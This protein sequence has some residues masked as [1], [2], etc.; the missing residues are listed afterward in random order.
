MAGKK[1]KQVNVR[2]SKKQEASEVTPEA[3]GSS[4]QR[5]PIGTTSKAA[6]SSGPQIEQIC[7]N[8]QY[9]I[10]GLLGPTCGNR[11]VEEFGKR[12]SDTHTSEGFTAKEVLTRRVEVIPEEADDGLYDPTPPHSSDTFEEDGAETAEGE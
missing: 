11:E 5:K 9:F 7:F 1:D 8:C 12:V 6:K 4:K 3:S 10:P 2:K